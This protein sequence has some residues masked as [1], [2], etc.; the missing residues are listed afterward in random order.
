MRPKRIVEKITAFTLS[1]MIA[2]SSIAVGSITNTNQISAAQTNTKKTEAS[3]DTS[4]YGKSY[5]EVAKLYGDNVQPYSDCV[6]D[7]EDLQQAF[8]KIRED[9]A[10]NILH[11]IPINEKATDV[12]TLTKALSVPSNTYILAYG[13]INF[14]TGKDSEG[15]QTQGRF[16]ISGSKNVCIRGNAETKFVLSSDDTN[17]INIVDGSNNINIV[18]TSFETK[19]TC[20]NSCFISASNSANLSFTNLKFKGNV[21]RAFSCSKIGN[22][23]FTNNT[24][25]NLT[26]PNNES[27]I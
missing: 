8:L 11:V 7:Q 21:K 10:D 26:I 23:K 24:I 19:A 4:W 15:N 17:A 20:Y 3:Y 18:N 25:S 12:F 1:G 6:A 5:E 16:T 22:T 13:T 27:A 14:S 9:D 2:L